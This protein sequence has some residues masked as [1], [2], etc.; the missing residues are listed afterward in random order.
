MGKSVFESAVVESINSLRREV[1]ELRSQVL[2]LKTMGAP[3][4][5]TGSGC[6][7]CCLYVRV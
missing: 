1:G 6:K 5:Q 4:S 7:W 3:S 2:N